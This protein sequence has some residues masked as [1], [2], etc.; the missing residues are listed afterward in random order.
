MNF[1]IRYRGDAY[2]FLHYEKANVKFTDIYLFIVKYI[3]SKSFNF[4]KYYIYKYLLLNSVDHPN[5]CFEIFKKIR[6]KDSKKEK[7][8]EYSPTIREHQIKLLM[9]F[10]NIFNRDKKVNKKKLIYLDRV[11]DDLFEDIRYKDDINKVLELISES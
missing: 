11:F 10:Y 8:T 2:C 3:D 4:K 9:G 1:S 7:E 6:L 5:E